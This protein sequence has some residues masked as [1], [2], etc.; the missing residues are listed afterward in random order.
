MICPQP[1]NGADKV[2]T[3]CQNHPTEE[4][5][6]VYKDLTFPCD[7]NFYLAG[8][9]L[10]VGFYASALLQ[11]FL[12]NNSFTWEISSPRQRNPFFCSI[13]Y[14]LRRHRSNGQFLWEDLLKGGKQL[15]S[16]AGTAA[17]YSFCMREPELEKLS[18]ITNLHQML[19]PFI[20]KCGK[21]NP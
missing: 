12:S 21:H 9:F 17:K 8:S 20:F 3:P 11:H 19:L 15:A 16:K 10:T 6:R 5:G 18:L 4:F 2:E 1:K 14:E 7:G 13:S